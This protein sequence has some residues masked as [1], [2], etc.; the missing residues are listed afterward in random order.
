MVS[1]PQVGRKLRTPTHTFYIRAKPFVIQPFL[2]APVLAGETV[3]NVLL[4]SRVVSSPIASPLIGWWCEYYLFY[5]KL[6]DL[7]DRDAIVAA[8]IDPTV[9]MSALAEAADISYYHSGGSPNWAKKCLKRVV[10]EYFRDETHAW[11]YATVDGLPIAQIQGNSWLDSAM[12]SSALVTNDVNADLNAN[13]TITASE[14]E[15]ALSQWNMLKA[16]NLVD[17][18]FED[19]LRSFGVKVSDEQSRRPELIRY[20]REWTYP[21][22]HVDP[23]T[24]TPVSAVSWSIQ[25]RADKDRFIK[26]PGFIFGVTLTRPKVYLAN[27]KSSGVEL[28]ET[29]YAWLPAMLRG[30]PNASLVRQT[31]T[32]S[33][34]TGIGST[35]WVADVKDLL[36]YGDQFLSVDP[37]ATGIQSVALPDNA[38][39]KK[40]YVASADI[41][42][43]FPGT[44]KYVRQDGVVRMSILGA[45]TETSPRGSSLGYTI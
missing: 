24:G 31:G 32:N 12:L 15:R 34:L 33:P 43:M 36:L 35:E 39:V 14:I 1:V 6:T 26:E 18:S 25:E 2:I 27:Q 23:T 38:L 7:D 21:V 9:N 30:D 4:Q 41:D 11:N 22:N 13:A 17:M 45:Q 42:G 10:E 16:G 44:D 37:T 28:M 5:V 29:A 40:R 8:L 3:K 20:V 19:Y